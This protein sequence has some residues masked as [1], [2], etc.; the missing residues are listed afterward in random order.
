VHQ[1][2]SRRGHARPRLLVMVTSPLTARSFLTGQLR[3]CRAHGF[4]VTVACHPDPVLFD[5]A[6]SEKV[7]AAGIPM[8]RELRFASD[9]RALV[10]TCLLVRRL[11]P[12]VINV[13]TPKAGLLGTIAGLLFRVPARVYTM[14]GLR[15]ETASGVM[16]ALLYLVELL[17]CRTAHRVVCVSPSLRERAIAL[18][19]VRPDRAVVLGNGSCNGVDADRFAPERFPTAQITEL[20][21]QLRIPDDVYVVGFVGR[22][23]RDKGV[24]EL[25][26]AFAQVRV[27]LPAV[28]LLV[29]GDFEQGDPVTANVEHFLRSDDDVVLVGVVDDPAPYYQLMD[30]LVLPTHREGLGYVPLEAA[31]ARRPVVTTN[32]TGAVDT[33]IPGETGVLVDV[34]DSRTLAREL[35]ALLPDGERRE[36]LGRRGR[37]R[38]VRD[39]QQQRIWDE[40]IAVYSDLVDGSVARIPG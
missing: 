12:D 24:T 39:F 2:L 20:R 35:S 11:R 4:D 5:V 15:L 22:L 38:V 28:R 40:L 19:L 14:H 8:A 37:E 33:V 9:V 26:N 27:R 21:Q 16:K 3:Q 10:A 30:V 13:G 25:A 23:T 18:R 1:R 31:A 32:A 17:C 6:H 36:R 29:I 34:G 7:H